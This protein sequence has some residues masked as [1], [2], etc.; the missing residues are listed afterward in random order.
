MKCIHNYKYFKQYYVLHFTL[1]QNFITSVD[2]SI[3]M[4]MIDLEKKM[5]NLEK[6]SHNVLISTGLTICHI[7]VI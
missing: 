6:M 2:I 3:F 4:Y 1:Y 7:I 5:N